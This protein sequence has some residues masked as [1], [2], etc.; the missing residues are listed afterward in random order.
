MRLTK[1]V[2]MRTQTEV[3]MKRKV[4][5]VFP[6]PQ[7]LHFMDY[8]YT[9]ESF[10]LICY[11]MSA[12]FDPVSVTHSSISTDNTSALSVAESETSLMVIS[13]CQSFSCCGEDQDHFFCFV[14]EREDHRQQWQPTVSLSLP[15]TTTTIKHSTN[16]L[17]EWKEGIVSC[18]RYITSLVMIIDGLWK[19][20][21]NNLW[22]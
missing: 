4:V 9:L 5:V 1:R 12:L 8:F 2:Q 19:G 6:K 11:I 14:E 18:R 3:R 7:S 16:A 21:E 20:F 10:M 13:E 15:P 17:V 22:S